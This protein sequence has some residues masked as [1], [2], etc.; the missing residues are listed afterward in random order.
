MQHHP[1]D[2]DKVADQGKAG[3]QQAYRHPVEC[4][5]QLRGALDHGGVLPVFFGQGQQSIAQGGDRPQQEVPE[6]DR[7]KALVGLPQQMP[8]DPLQQLLGIV[9]ADVQVTLGHMGRRLQVLPTPGIAEGTETGQQ[10]TAT[11]AVDH[12]QQMHRQR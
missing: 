1:A 12:H 3:G 11:Q 5:A 8:F 4:M 6:N 9:G 7:E 10:I 2:R